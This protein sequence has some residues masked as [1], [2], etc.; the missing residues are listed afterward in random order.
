MVVNT[1]W[2]NGRGVINVAI[3]TPVDQIAGRASTVPVRSQLH[4]S[5]TTQVRL[6]GSDADGLIRMRVI[7]GPA[8]SPGP[9][10]PISVAVAVARVLQPLSNLHMNG[11]CDT[12]T[13]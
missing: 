8:S 1:P 5:V 6:Q 4:H 13:Y 12:A 9:R 7:M 10:N 3:S 11:I 2:C